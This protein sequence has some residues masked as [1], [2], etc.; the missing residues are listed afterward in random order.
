[1][2][3]YAKHNL[4]RGSLVPIHVGNLWY[5]VLSRA[6]LAISISKI[7]FLIFYSV[8]MFYQSVH[9][10]LLKFLYLHLVFLFQ[11]TDA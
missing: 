3:V 8:L 11:A 5:G 7:F 2:M 1:M 10:T 9:C 6:F 4:E